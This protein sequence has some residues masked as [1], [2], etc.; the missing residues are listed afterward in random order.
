VKIHDITLHPGEL[1]FLPVGWWHHVR[2]LDVSITLT[3]TNFRARNDFASF[4]ETYGEI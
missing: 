1:F 2:G 4:Y 3:C